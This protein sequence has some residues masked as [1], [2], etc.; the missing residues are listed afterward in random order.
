VRVAGGQR[1][2]CVAT[3]AAVGCKAGRR[4][5][6]AAASRHR[7]AWQLDAAVARGAAVV[8]AVV[9]YGEGGRV[10]ADARRGRARRAAHALCG[11]REHVG[12]VRRAAAAAA[13]ALGDRVVQDAEDACLDEVLA[14]LRNERVTS[15]GS[16][17]AKA[18]AATIK[19]GNHVTSKSTYQAGTAL[20]KRTCVMRDCSARSAHCRC[21]MQTTHQADK[22]QRSGSASRFAESRDLMK[23]VRTCVMSDCSARSSRC[24]GAIP[25]G[26]LLSADQPKWRSRASLRSRL[27]LICRQ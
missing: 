3:G 4:V 22:G 8:A 19:A 10:R 6:A 23:Y 1:R 16:C 26:P 11:S 20:A 25:S 24:C 17:K 14:D 21:A 9:P 5:H 15:R 18:M 13:A 27:C 2:G 12:D 7:G